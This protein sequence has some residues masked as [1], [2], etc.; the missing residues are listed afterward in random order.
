MLSPRAV[1]EIA[2]AAESEARSRVTA[3]LSMDSFDVIADLTKPYALKIIPDALGLAEEDREIML[4]YRKY[5]L[6]GRGLHR[7]DP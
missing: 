3:P 6:K 1:R 4:V 2:N 5:L 7:H